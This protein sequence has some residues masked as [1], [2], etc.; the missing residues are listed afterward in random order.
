MPADLLDAIS[1]ASLVL[2]WYENLPSSDM[3]PK[4]M[5]VLSDDLEEHFRQLREKRSGGDSS[6]Q[7]APMMQNEYARGR[8][9][10]AR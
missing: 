4:W 5:W 8:G 1:Q 2:S 9:R 7:P 3:P 6:E 10:N